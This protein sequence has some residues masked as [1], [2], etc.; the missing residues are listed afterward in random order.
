VPTSR[1][2]LV[3]RIAEELVRV[4]PAGSGAA[5]LALDAA[6]WAGLDLVPD[7]PAALLSRG[8]TT[9]VVD[10][11]DFLRPASVRLERGRDD[12]DAF[13]E[14]WIDVAALRREVLDP[15]APDGSRRILPTLWNVER[16]RAT[17]AAY[18]D[19]PSDAVVVVSG[20]FLL[21]LGLPFELTV[22]VA[23]SPAARQRRVPPEDAVRELP[24]WDRY[25]ADVRPAHCADLVI[26]ADDPAR[27]ALVD[28]LR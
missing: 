6:P 11:R 28:R 12:S 24:A 15:L 14:D 1:G 5:R 25:D 22:H 23:L 4:A 27:P 19:V 8:R 17:R 10:V 2:A 18:L 20:W 3:D 21:G 7:L 26:R 13:Y 16:D 9:Y